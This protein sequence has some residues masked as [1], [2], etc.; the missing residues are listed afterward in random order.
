M[1]LPNRLT[2]SRLAMAGAFLGVMVARF[3][4]HESVALAVFFFASLTDLVDGRVARKRGLI[5]NFG[6]LMD[7]LADKI[8]TGAAFIMFVER[9]LMPGWMVVVIVSRELVITGLRLLAASRSV[10]LSAER[11]GKHKTLWQVIA[12]VAILVVASYP[13]WGDA[14]RQIFGAPIRGVA[15]TARF[16]EAARWIAVSLTVWSGCVYLWRNRRLY[17][18]GA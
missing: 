1:N 11:Y 13:Q 10:V 17:L 2:V 8:L 14:G 5:T 4:G 6:A 7:P 9:G 12:I 15:W 18:D 16:A 3:P